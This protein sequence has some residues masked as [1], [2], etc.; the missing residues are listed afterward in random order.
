MVST[1]GQAMVG[2]PQEA[3]V[4]QN[5]IA[6]GQAVQHMLFTLP[7]DLRAIIWKRARFS[8]AQHRLA[9]HI[10]PRHEFSV[11]RASHY[12]TFDRVQVRLEIRCGKFMIISKARM[13][14]RDSPWTYFDYYGVLH[15]KLTCWM[16]IDG[17]A[18]RLVINCQEIVSSWYNTFQE[19]WVNLRP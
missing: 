12:S 9:G 5:I 19:G 8:N 7:A 15:D 13:H 3:P 16:A 10:T 1:T 18:V 2:S 11:N 4:C 6:G 14:N 17:S